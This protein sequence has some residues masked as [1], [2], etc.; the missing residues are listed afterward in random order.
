MPWLGNFFA[1]NVPTI[2]RSAPS[3]AGIYV[4]WKNG[5]WIYVGATEH[6]RARLLALAT[7]DNECVSRDV[8]TDFGFELIATEEHRR[9]RW[10]TLIRELAPSCLCPPEG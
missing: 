9:A 1:F 10:E 8:P 4:L 7:G 5:R 3:A 6:L 2:E